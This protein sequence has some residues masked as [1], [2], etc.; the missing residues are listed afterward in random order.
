[1]RE[2]I[3]DNAPWE[4]G[5]GYSRAVKIGNTLEISGTTSVVNGVTACRGDAAGQTRVILEK[6]TVVL[7]KAGMDL[8]DV[9]RTRI[10]VVDISAWK[11]IGAVHL[12]FFGDV[13]P[14]T[15]MVEVNRL[16]DDELLVEIEAVAVQSF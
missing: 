7:K 13:R 11:E 9:V 2:N 14:A 3:S 5:V 16:I 8:S 1:M 12:E 15:T 6:I 4:A 10:Y